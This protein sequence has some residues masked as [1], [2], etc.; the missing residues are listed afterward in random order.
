MRSARTTSRTW[1]REVH[2]RAPVAGPPA[3]APRS[4]QAGRC[5]VPLV[6]G[7]ARKSSRQALRSGARIAAASVGRVAAMPAAAP[8][9][10]HWPCRLAPAVPIAPSAPRSAPRS[11]SMPRRSAR[12]SAGHGRASADGSRGAAA[13]RGT[14]A[15][16][17]ADPSA[18]SC[19]APEP[20]QGHLGQALLIELGVDQ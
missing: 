3:T 1:P 4:P 16:A 19:C 9:S 18:R 20:G 14:A 8:P 11:A 2:R 5:V 6:P 15:P 7:W 12:S 10:R 17:P 13:R